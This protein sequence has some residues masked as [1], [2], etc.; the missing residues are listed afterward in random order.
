MMTKENFNVCNFFQTFINILY[1]AIQLDMYNQLEGIND[2]ASQ[3]SPVMNF[4]FQLIQKII[5][6]SLVI[7]FGILLGLVIALFPIAMLIQFMNQQS[8]KTEITKTYDSLMKRY[9]ENT[10]F[11]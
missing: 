4:T 11:I 10:L 8:E 6:Y 3:V 7:A 2:A 1:F 5:A 9:R